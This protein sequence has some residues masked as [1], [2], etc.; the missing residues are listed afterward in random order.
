MNECSNAFSFKIISVANHSQMITPIQACM[1]KTR[2]HSRQHL[3]PFSSLI[4]QQARTRDKEKNALTVLI[5]SVFGHGAVVLTGVAVSKVCMQH[6]TNFSKVGLKSCKNKVMVVYI[7]CIITQ[8]QPEKMQNKA[9]QT[10][11]TTFTPSVLVLGAS[12]SEHQ[13]SALQNL[14]QLVSIPACSEIKCLYSRHMG[15]IRLTST[16]FSLDLLHLSFSL[17][18]IGLDSL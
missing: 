10:K 14:K 2:A 13:V 11:T 6:V 17:T 3:S 4:T 15:F 8:L 16:S 5:I 18:F 7:Y 9:T 1:F 12:K